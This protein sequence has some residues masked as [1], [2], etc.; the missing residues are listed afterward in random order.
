[1]SAWQVLLTVGVILIVVDY[2]ITTLFLFPFGAGFIAAA[3]VLYLTQSKFWAWT[4]FALVS[5]VAFYFSF[6]LRKRLKATED[7]VEDTPSLKG[8]VG[9][10]V[11]KEGDF[12]K[13]KFDT[14]LLGETLWL[15]KSLENRPLK[16]GDKVEVVELK[17]NTLIVK[18]LKG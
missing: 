11:G 18:N 3:A 5:I 14:G 8:A 15:A 1:M 10:V 4:S 9:K 16:I 7:K 17:G 6:K 12:F 2:F 13:V